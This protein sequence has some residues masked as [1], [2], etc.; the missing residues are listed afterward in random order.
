MRTTVTIDDDV[1]ESAM[2]L[3][4]ASGDSLGS[5]L[6][7][8]ARRG[9]RVHGEFATKN[10]LPVFPVPANAPLIPSGR[11]KQMESDERE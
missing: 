8:L 9:L 2:A 4:Q 10:S 6:S 5:V 1:Y 7:Q 3:S 11:A